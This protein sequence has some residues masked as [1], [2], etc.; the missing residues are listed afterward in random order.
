M[1]SARPSARSSRAGR[2]KLPVLERVRGAEHRFEDRDPEP[3]ARR[4]A[5][6][7]PSSHRHG[8]EDLARRG[9]AARSRRDSAGSAWCTRWK[10]QRNGSAVVR[11]VPE[12]RHSVEPEHARRRRRASAARERVQQ[13]EAVRRRPARDASTRRRRTRARAESPPRP[14]PRFTARPGAVTRAARAA[15]RR[16]R[17]RA[18]PRPRPRRRR[19]ATLARVQTGSSGRCGSLGSST[20]IRVAHAHLAAR[21]HDP[22]HARLATRFPSRSRARVAFIRPGAIPSSCTHGLRRP[23]TSTTALAPRCSRAPRRQRQ[24]IHAARGHVLAHLARR[25]DRSRARAARRA[26]RRE[27]GAPGA[28]SA[29]SGRA[30]RA[31]GASR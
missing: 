14:E 9:S 18:P 6:I 4:A 11:A 24:Q 25:H 2:S 26:A 13:P 21:E 31:S 8:Q 15:R 16:A 22:H 10:R 3:A 5:A 17:A 28:G 1:I 12:I 20:P 23:V 19:R 29:G 7:A 27:S 30:P